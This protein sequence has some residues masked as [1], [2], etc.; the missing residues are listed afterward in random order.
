[1][2]VF[3]FCELEP[4]VFFSTSAYAS[5]SEVMVTVIGETKFG[6]RI[7]SVEAFDELL[8]F[9]F[10]ASSAEV[11]SPSET[12]EEEEVEAAEAEA[13]E[14]VA[15]FAAR[16]RSSTMASAS[17]RIFGSSSS[18]CAFTRSSNSL[19]SRFCSVSARTTFTS[20]VF[21]ASLYS[22]STRSLDSAKRRST[23]ASIFCS[24]RLSI[25]SSLAL[26]LAMT[27]LEMREVT[28]VRMRAS[29]SAV[30]EL[31]SSDAAFDST[32][33]DDEEDE[34]GTASAT[35]VVAL[36]VV[37]VS[38]SFCFSAASE[39]PKTPAEVGTASCCSL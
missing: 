38:S 7:D 24:T 15:S 4:P 27:S 35:V 12:G 17:A 29:C 18:S 5:S 20:A 6:S 30:N 21:S 3:L 9:S 31:V 10:P 32:E 33:L 26:V 19:S 8:P 25:A 28:C 34:T 2:K 22:S 14:V 16:N 1:M 13:D 39:G 36:A 23:S 37:A 11:S